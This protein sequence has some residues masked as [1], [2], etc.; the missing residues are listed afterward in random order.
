MSSAPKFTETTVGPIH[1]YPLT[2][3][4]NGVAVSLQAPVRL[5]ISNVDA[6]VHAPDVR[7]DFIAFALPGGGTKMVSSWL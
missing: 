4:V 7:G 2:I 5:V 1:H 3:N 6:T